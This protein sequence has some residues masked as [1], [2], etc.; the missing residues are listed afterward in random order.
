MNGNTNPWLV[1]ALILFVTTTTGIGVSIHFYQNYTNTDTLYRDV[2][3][4]VN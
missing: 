1:V 4:T 3:E 2:L